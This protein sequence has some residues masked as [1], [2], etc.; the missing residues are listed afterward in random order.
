[1]HD[2]VPSGAAFQTSRA[3]AKASWPVVSPGSGFSLAFH[4]H[5]GTSPHPWEE[6]DW[7]VNSKRLMCLLSLIL[8]SKTLDSF[9]VLP[10]ALLPCLL[11][12]AYFITICHGSVYVVSDGW[13]RALP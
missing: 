3:E 4:R 7:F 10:T 13:G 6:G 2:G 1:M 9:H 5:L 12:T 11:D 8:V